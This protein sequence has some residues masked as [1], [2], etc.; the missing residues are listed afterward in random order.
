MASRP[1]PHRTLDGPQPLTPMA[2]TGSPLPIPPGP[3]PQRWFGR[4]ARI[5]GQVIAGPDP[6]AFLASHG[7][8][9][10]HP[11]AREGRP[12]DGGDDW[13]SGHSPLG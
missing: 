1:D 8:L 3:Q 9:R 7:G 10:V 6:L 5:L 11:A 12:L 2:R 13:G 4:M